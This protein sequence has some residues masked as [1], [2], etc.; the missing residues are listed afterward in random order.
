MEDVFISNRNGGEF[1][2]TEV[3]GIAAAAAPYRVFP[4]RLSVSR[5]V[6]DAEAKLLKYKGN[7]KVVIAEP[8]IFSFNIEKEHDFIFLGCND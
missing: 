1:C 7:P 8:D 6:G 4:G 5:T 3:E 2:R